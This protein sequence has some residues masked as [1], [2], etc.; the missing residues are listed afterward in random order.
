M[1][2]QEWRPKPI[3]PLF[4]YWI[5]S[6]DSLLARTEI[7]T[8]DRQE[9]AVGAVSAVIACHRE[10][11][12]DSTGYRCRPPE[13]PLPL[14]ATVPRAVAAAAGGGHHWNAR[15][16]RSACRSSRESCSHEA[17]GQAC[18]QSARTIRSPERADNPLAGAR[19]HAARDLLAGARKQADD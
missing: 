9:S 15:Q 16:E 1:V 13:P 17:S 4:I 6:R 14:Q 12:L 2:C 18:C 19:R 7:K 11:V 5:P 8:Q 10:T 3:F